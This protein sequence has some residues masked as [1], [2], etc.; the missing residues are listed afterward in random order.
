MYYVYKTVYMIDENN[1][2]EPL[3]LCTCAD[4][5][6]H[7]YCLKERANTVNILNCLFCGARYPLERRPKPLLKVT[8][9]YII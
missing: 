8:S 1:R 6:I 3:R 4:K 7:V 5:F 9:Q 2:G